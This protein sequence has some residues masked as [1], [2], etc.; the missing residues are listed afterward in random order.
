MDGLLYI[1]E[2]LQQLFGKIDIFDFL[3]MRYLSPTSDFDVVFE[4]RRNDTRVLVD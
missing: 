3:E 2:I 1:V 4:T